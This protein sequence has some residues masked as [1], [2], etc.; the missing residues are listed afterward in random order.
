[1]HGAYHLIKFHAKQDIIVILISYQ[2]YGSE[3]VSISEFQ[4]N[5]G[6]QSGPVPPLI[7]PG[8]AYLNNREKKTA[9]AGGLAGQL[10]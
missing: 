8:N 2:F 3:N 10:G 9:V 4:V 7:M 1:L 5:L 6:E